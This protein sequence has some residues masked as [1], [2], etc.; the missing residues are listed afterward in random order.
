MTEANGETQ[1][2]NGESKTTEDSK[3]SEQKTF[4][5]EQL[6]QIINERLERERK[7]YEKKEAERKKAEEIEKL[8]GEEKLN[9][10]HKAEMDKILAERDEAL[11]S[12]KIMKASSDL[13]KLGYDTE[14]ATVVIGAT[15]EETEKNIKNFDKMVNAI[16]EKRVQEN[17]AK[18]SPKQ[19]TSGGEQKNAMLEQ[20]RKVAGLK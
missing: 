13:A 12:S 1:T 18:G 11:R 6:D 10:K 20:M 19:P 4:T 8:S 17:L 2:N 9:A 5:Q 15:D 14:F 7:S 16:V 3:A